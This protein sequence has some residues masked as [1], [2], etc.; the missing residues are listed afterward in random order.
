MHIQ[1]A[2]DLQKIT[3]QVHDMWFD[4]EQIKESYKNGIVLI[5]LAKETKDLEKSKAGKVIK[6][7]KIHKL[8]IKDTEKVGYYDFNE[9][10]YDK[11]K[12]CLSI[13]TGV[14][15]SIKLYVEFIEIVLEN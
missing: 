7:S 5:K 1:E 11:G 13:T 15:V 14:P 12:S 6:I 9:I 8:D 3:E 10:K 4:I 2:K